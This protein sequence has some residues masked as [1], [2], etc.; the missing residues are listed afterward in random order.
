MISVSVAL[1]APMI[2]GIQSPLIPGGGVAFR[3]VGC[4][5]GERFVLPD[6][7]EF[8]CLINGFYVAWLWWD[9]RVQKSKDR[10]NYYLAASYF[11][12]I[13][14]LPPIHAVDHLSGIPFDHCMNNKS[15]QNA[16][17]IQRKLAEMLRLWCCRLAGCLWPCHFVS[18]LIQWV[19]ALPDRLVSEL[20]R[21]RLALLMDCFY[22]VR[23]M[24][25]VQLV[26]AGPSEVVGRKSLCPPP[27]SNSCQKG[28]HCLVH[29]TDT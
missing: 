22:V 4:S 8:R 17:Y 3:G 18:F 20:I 2:V 12:G 21:V 15:N 23:R 26:G 19:V 27:N 13:T 28:W 25:V 14:R 11:V 9:E 10:L 24:F 6:N 5:C 16:L 29:E 7:I 1:R